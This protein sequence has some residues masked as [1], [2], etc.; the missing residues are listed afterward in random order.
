MSGY[1]SCTG[2][3]KVECDMTSDPNYITTV[4]HHDAE[5]TQLVT[6]HANPGSYF[7]NIDYYGITDTQLVSIQQQSLHC[8]QFVKIE[9]Y[10]VSSGLIND[11]WLDIKG[12]KLPW[13][14]DDNECQCSLNKACRENRTV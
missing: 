1:G 9:C 8:E 13:Q 7:V 2:V 4:V 6:G 10:G 3:I 14:T 11:Y 12:K 5:N